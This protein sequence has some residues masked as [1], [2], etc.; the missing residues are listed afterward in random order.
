MH[1]SSMRP[2]STCSSSR[3]MAT[4]GADMLSSGDSL[5]GPDVISPKLY[6]RFAQPYETRIAAHAHALG[7][8]YVLHICGKTDKI[9]GGMIETGADGM[10]LDYKTDV[11]LANS[12]DER[13]GGVHR[14]Y[15]SVGGAGEQHTRRVSG[16]RPRGGR[17]VSGAIPRFVL[18]AGCAIPPT[19]PPENLRALIEAGRL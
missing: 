18:N 16:R 3:L 11:G 6:A 4:T 9:L 7:F 13:P 2:R 17:G 5:S 12:P 8:P 10:E 15:R 14:Q 1:C 19:T